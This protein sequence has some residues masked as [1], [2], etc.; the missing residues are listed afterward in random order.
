MIIPRTA[1]FECVARSRLHSKASILHHFTRRRGGAPAQVT[2]RRRS[3]R[4]AAALTQALL[5]L[6]FPSV[7]SSATLNTPHSALHCCHVTVVALHPA[8]Q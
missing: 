8:S 2:V 7:S 3:D 1:A 4:R 5:W 6:L